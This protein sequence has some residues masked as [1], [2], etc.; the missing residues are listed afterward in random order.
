MLNLDD[1]I[2]MHFF[3]LRSREL[4]NSF[5]WHGMSGGLIRTDGN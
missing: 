1:E 4:L 5:L 2:S 3:P